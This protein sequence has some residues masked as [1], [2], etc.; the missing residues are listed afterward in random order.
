MTPKGRG[1]CGESYWCGDQTRSKATI[2]HTVK[3][4]II[5]IFIIFGWFVAIIHSGLVQVLGGGDTIELRQFGVAKFVV[6][7][8]GEFAEVLMKLIRGNFESF[9]HL[10]RLTRS[11]TTQTPLNLLLES[12]TQTVMLTLS[13]SKA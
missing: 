8:G 4:S 13:S 9:H 5:I 10:S 7:V 11:L 3:P 1:W 6:D 12:S 2:V